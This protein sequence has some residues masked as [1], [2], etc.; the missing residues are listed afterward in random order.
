[1]SAY[2]K[3]N[4]RAMSALGALVAATVVTGLAGVPA[5][6]AT[7]QEQLAATAVAENGNGPCAHGGYDDGLSQ[8]SSCDGHG[9]QSQAWCAD[10]V[11]WVWAHN[12][13]SGMGMLTDAAASF[14]QYGLKYGTKSNTPHVGDAVVY[15]YSNGWAQHVAM[16]TGISNGVVTITGGNQGHSQSSEGLVS[17]NSTTHYAVGDAPWGQVISG[18]I[19]PVLQKATPPKVSLQGLP[20]TSVTGV[21]SLSSSVSAGTYGISTVEYYLDG[22]KIATRSTA[23]YSYSFDTSRVPDGKHILS[24][25]VTDTQGNTGGDRAQIITSNGESGSTF[26]ADF[27]GDGKS[28]VGVLY[29]YGQTSDGTNHVGLWTYLSNGSG[30]NK[31]VKVWDNV[32]AGSGSWNWDRSKVTSGDF[33]GDGKSDVAVLYNNG[34]QSDGTNRTSLWTFTSNGSGFNKPVKVWDNVDAGSGSWNWNRSKVTSGDFNGDGRTDVGVLYNNGQQSDGTNRTSLWTFT[35]TGSGFG[36]PAKKWDNVDAGSGSW[37]W[38]RSK[39]TA[40]D[41]TGD[42]KADVA[43]LYDNGQQSDGNN[44]TTLWTF[45]STGSGFNAPLRKWDNTESDVTSW[46]WDRSKLTV[47]DY[48]GDGKADIG[49]LYNNGQTEDSRNKSALWTF[50]ST[51]A[52]FGNPLRKWDSG[53]DSWNTDASKLTSGDFDGDGKTDIGVL[54]GYGQQDDGTNRTGLWKFTS[55]GPAFNNPTLA[56]DSA[57]FTSWNWENSKLA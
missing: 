19:S 55:T 24:V 13:V 3:V 37:N 35:S 17:T 18:Y 14:Y 25:E 7:P 16:V 27:N 54:Y 15:G 1:M 29:D 2:V 30:F 40:G 28:D 53:S 48:T 34:Q 51:G 43:V 42:G 21:A 39:V 33:N 23:P 8:S 56:F 31:P 41:F 9:G 47:G 36:N 32:D 45:T 20:G 52:G 5:H 10:F 57:N 22:E 4:R 6:A 44:R 11:G 49:V 46:N 50:V 12:N 26:D 38:D